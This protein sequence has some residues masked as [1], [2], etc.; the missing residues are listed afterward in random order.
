[1]IVHNAF[2][3][4][5]HML[6]DRLTS[7]QLSAADRFVTHNVA[8]A[9]ELEA[10]FPNKPTAVFPHPTFDDV[11]A[12]HGRLPRRSSLELLFFGLVRPYK[13]LDVLLDAM[14]L[15]TRDDISLTIAGEFWQDQKAAQ[16]KVND[17]GADCSVE[18]LARYV[19]DNEMA[20]LFERADAVVLPYRSVSGSGVVSLAF[21]YRK[22]II[23]SD[24][25]GFSEILRA[26]GAGRLF[27]PGD[28]SDLAATLDRL[29]KDDLAGASEAAARSAKDLTWNKFVST[30]LGEDETAGGTK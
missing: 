22:P 4:E 10:R 18:L 2:D 24:L 26:S 15:V 14:S 7:W 17:L 28:A 19:D 6:K 11:P 27:K 8:L 1:M 9:Q 29:T 20:E 12:A 25:P 23:A 3:H 30:I 13:G 5:A 16:T 21:H